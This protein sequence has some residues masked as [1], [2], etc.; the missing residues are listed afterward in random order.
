MTIPQNFILQSTNQRNNNSMA[1]PPPSNMASLSTEDIH[2]GLQSIPQELYDQIANDVLK[3]KTWSTSKEF[4]AQQ[5]I[6][7][8]SRMHYL[9]LRPIREQLRFAHVYILDLPDLPYRPSPIRTERPYNP[10][11]SVG[12]SYALFP[13]KALLTIESMRTSVRISKSGFRATKTLS[14]GCSR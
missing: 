5:S 7:H 11:K 6:D 1:S 8:D 13:P 10:P 14:I 12:K 2:A 4:P 9:Q 3:G